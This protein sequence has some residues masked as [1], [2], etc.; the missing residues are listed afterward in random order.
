M[1]PL[2]RRA[3]W[4]KPAARGEVANVGGRAFP[5]E[6]A[7]P[8]PA[9]SGRRRADLAIAYRAESTDALLAALDAA[10]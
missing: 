3:A 1:A 5:A 7:G 2:T 6:P 4:S 8:L 10:V 9:A